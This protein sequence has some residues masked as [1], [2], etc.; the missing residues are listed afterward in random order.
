MADE[1]FRI[2]PALVKEG[3]AYVRRFP[4]EMEAA[5]R[6]FDSGPNTVMPT[7]AISPCSFPG[8]DNAPP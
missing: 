5:I 2:D 6:P 3:M 4:E 1:Y 8:R 7:G